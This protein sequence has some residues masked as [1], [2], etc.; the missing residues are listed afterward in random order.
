MFELFE[1]QAAN[2]T[3]FVGNGGID[4]PKQD[5]AALMMGLE[6]GLISVR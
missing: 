2:L 4:S 1:Q 5:E 6:F 3:F